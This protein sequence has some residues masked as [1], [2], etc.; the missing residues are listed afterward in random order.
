MQSYKEEK[1]HGVGIIKKKNIII[2]GRLAKALGPDEEQKVM[3]AGS[4]H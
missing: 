1:C 4:I 2:K 3:G